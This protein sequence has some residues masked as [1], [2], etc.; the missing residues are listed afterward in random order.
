MILNVI[1]IV[2]AIV[3]E[4]RKSMT[5]STHTSAI[6]SQ[7]KFLAQLSWNNGSY[8]PESAVKHVFKWNSVSAWQEPKELLELARIV[9]SYR[10]KTI[11]EI[12]SARGGTLFVWCQMAH[13][14]ATVLS[15]DLPGGRYGGGY[16]E[17]R[18]STMKRLKQRGQKLHL[19]RCDSHDAGTLRRVQELF[20][21]EKIDFL[22]IDGDHRYE[23]VKQDF[24]MYR[25]LVAKGGII[26]FHDILEA[27][28]DTG[29]DV[30]RF[31]N[32]IKEQF[33]HREI[34]ADRQQQGYGIGLLLV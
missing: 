24:D 7:A 15:L 13:P 30:S 22:F 23:G 10:P 18:I 2:A 31:W 14:K 28:E 33:Y 11:L 4:S 21:S 12:G 5:L 32:E 26:G 20:Q 6:L 25:P 9:R 19:L 29:G 34:V 3:L 17:G 16:Q 27:P 8:D 1:L